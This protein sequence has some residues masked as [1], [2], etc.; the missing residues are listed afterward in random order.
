MQQLRIINK[1]RSTLYRRKGF[2]MYMYIL[3]IYMFMYM[4]AVEER[5][6]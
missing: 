6:R 1:R 2:L 5:K 4:Y 3:Y